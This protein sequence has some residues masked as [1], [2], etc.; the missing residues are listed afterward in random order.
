MSSDR[1]QFDDPT[2]HA[3][4]SVWQRLREHLD[5]L[6]SVEAGAL[7]PKSLA[8]RL[9]ERAKVLRQ[10]MERPQAKGALLT[11]LAFNKQRER[12]GIPLDDV[13]AVEALEH[14]TSVPNAAD[15]IRGVAPWRGSIL[16]LIDLGRLFGRP[17]SG[18]ADLRACVIVETAGR[19]LAIVAYE[20]EEIISIP[21]SE[22][23]PAPDLPAEI[24]PEW[25]IG[26]HDE[27]RLIL[28]I[29]ELMKGIARL[30]KADS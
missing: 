14:F 16:S 19:R 11:F 25:V 5:T 24:A 30:Q 23:A 28:K 1:Q 4:S 15:F 9:A 27:N 20:V 10:R 26:V 3:A 18:L 22:L 8:E 2:P 17:E 7:D 29:S 21:E 12:Y 6:R 13:A